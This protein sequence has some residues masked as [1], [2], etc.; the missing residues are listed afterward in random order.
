MRIIDDDGKILSSI[1]KLEASGHAL[2]SFERL[3][4]RLGR[5]LF[6]QSRTDGAH[7]VVD[8]EKPRDAERQLHLAEI[9]RQRQLHAACMDADV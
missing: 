3:L 8:V 5:H 7:D 1:D 2:E 4:D 9:A 6:R